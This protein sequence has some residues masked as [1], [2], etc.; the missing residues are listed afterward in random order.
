MKTC[1]LCQKGSVVTGGY[2]NRIRATKYNPTGK[3]RKKPNLQWAF[4]EDGQRKLICSSCH[5]K[6]A[7]S[8]D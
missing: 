1:Y 3:K 7:L 8:K 5:K 2:S 6:M 4:L